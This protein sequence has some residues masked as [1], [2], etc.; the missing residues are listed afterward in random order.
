MDALAEM[1]CVTNT[2]PGGP[3]HGVFLLFADQRT[4]TNDF[5][6]LVNGATLQV[7]PGKNTS[8]PS[9]F[10]YQSGETGQVV[11]MID[12]SSDDKN[13]VMWIRD[14]R[15]MLGVATESDLTA[16]FKWWYDHG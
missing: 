7:C 14:R 8:A 2:L 4:M 11:C 15:L 12:E 1:V 10:S 5:Q 6:T 3:T 16:L 13:E 9:G